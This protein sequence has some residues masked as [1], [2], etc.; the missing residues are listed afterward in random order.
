MKNWSAE[1]R[2]SSHESCLRYAVRSR[3]ASS[4]LRAQPGAV[5]S[6][7]RRVFVGFKRQE[8]SGFSERDRRQCTWLQTSGNSDNALDA[9]RKADSHLE[10]FLSWV[11]GGVGE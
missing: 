11:S 5:Y 10:S 7:A 1:R 2:C 3:S 6:R 4:H 9:S 8:V